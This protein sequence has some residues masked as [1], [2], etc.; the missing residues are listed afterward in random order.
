MEAG[1][2]HAAKVRAD[3]LSLLARI[4]G[5]GFGATWPDADTKRKAFAFYREATGRKLDGN[6]HTCSVEVI[7][8][9][10]SHADLPRLGKSASPRLHEKRLSIC[11]ECEHLAW[12]GLNCSVCLCFVDIKARIKKQTCPKGKW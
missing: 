1:D 3:A 6:C 4:P 7:D 9:L 10:R 8:W 12:P 11:K 2:E 5:E